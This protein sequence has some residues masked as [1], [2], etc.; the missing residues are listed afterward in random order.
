M[1]PTSKSDDPPAA[2]KASAPAAAKPSG[3]RKASAPATRP[4]ARAPSRVPTSEISEPID[5]TTAA[6]FEQARAAEAASLTKGIEA[7]REVAKKARRHRTPLRALARLYERAGQWAPVADTMRREAALATKR[8]EKRALLQPMVGIYRDELKLGVR[9]VAVLQEI[10][11]LAPDDVRTLDDLAGLYEQLKRWSD[12]IAVLHKRAPLGATTDERV[13]TWLRVADLYADRVGNKSQAIEAY[14]KV[15]E[16]DPGSRPAIDRLKALYEARRDWAGLIELSRKEIALL[17]GERERAERYADAA[18]LAATK[19]DDPRLAM[20]LWADVLAEDVWNQQAIGELER[21]SEKTGEWQR[22]TDVL[23]R[24]AERSGDAEKQVELLEKLAFLLETRLEDPKGATA[25]WRSLLELRPDHAPALRALERLLLAAEEFEELESIYTAQARWKDLARVVERRAAAADPDL[26]KALLLRAATIYEDE[27]AQPAE[28]T[29]L[30][31]RVLAIDPADLEAAEALIPFYEAAN[32]SAALARVL[33][34]RL[35]HTDD[36]DVEREL[37]ARIADLYEEDGSEPSA[38]LRALLRQIAIEPEAPALRARAEKLAART[39]ELAQLART[40]EETWARASDRTGFV[41]AMLAAVRAHEQSGDLESALRV[42]ARVL[43]LEP[44]HAQATANSERLCALTERWDDLEAIYRTR[45]DRAESPEDRRKLLLQAAALYRDRWRDADRAR[46]TL[47]EALALDVEDTEPLLALAALDQ[48]A[49]ETAS[50]LGELGTRTIAIARGRE[51]ARLASLCRIYREGGHWSSLADLLRRADVVLAEKPEDHVTLLVE[52]AKVQESKLGEPDLARTSLE[53]A[54]TSS[55][56]DPRPLDALVDLYTRTGDWSSLGRVSAQRAR[57]SRDRDERAEL[58][59]DAAKAVTNAAGTIERALDLYQEVLSLQPENADALAAL[60]RFYRA[61]ERWSDLLEVLG[62]HCAATEDADQRTAIQLQAA[63]LCADELRDVRGAIGIYESILATDPTCAAALEALAELYQRSGRMAEYLQLLEARLAGAESDAERV[64]YCR[65]IASV[66]A[67]QLAR[68]DQAARYLERA[69]ALERGGESYRDLLSTYRR[70]RRFDA[71]ADVIERHL[72]A[73]D[74]PAA[75]TA[76]YLELGQLRSGQLG[77][78][79]GALEA[80]GATLELDPDNVRA[81]DALARLLEERGEHGEAARALELLASA[82]ESEP[83]R[84]AAHYRLGCLRRR[85]L[86]DAAAAEES[87]RRALESDP[88]HADAAF[89]LADIEEAAGDW[90][91]AVELLVNTSAA[92][93][94]PHVRARLLTRAGGLCEHRLG[95]DDRAA[96]LYA[97]ALDHDPGMA[98]AGTALVRICEAQDRLEELVQVLTVLLRHGDPHGRRWRHA[99]H[100]KLA[101][102]AESLGR[103][104]QALEHYQKAW[105]LDPADVPTLV[106]LTSLRRRLG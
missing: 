100:L 28:A 19:L 83:E 73:V 79:A 49:D 80:Y 18:R 21:L 51:P 53:Q 70:D 32:Q 3:A 11:E 30:F 35:A 69:F 74:D 106:G 12:L 27:L 93:P 71:V 81:L 92:A 60:E 33:E 90:D 84:A 6:L 61:E 94:T 56:E 78:V 66:Y 98:Q 76:A 16:L 105:E 23:R 36:D 91:A 17:D 99:L 59:L 52:L 13:A 31:E 65:Q 24:R 64:S 48:E 46:R 85:R 40:L 50:V 39:G 7:W 15:L 41:D 8:K 5:P 75:R 72:D 45:I 34:V 9:A 102:T 25:S 101:S 86:S 2:R 37:C 62:A 68:N 103:L 20:E 87:F 1:P 96:S 54:A 38:A 42:N 95:N 77:D 44:D 14:Q 58:L 104:D 89:E 22:F 4:A 55:P 63:R 47:H 88:S 43:E 97:R 57:L 67:N 29:R 26:Q 82:A 10:L